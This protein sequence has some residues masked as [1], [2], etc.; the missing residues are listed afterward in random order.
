MKKI[1]W[2]ITELIV[3]CNLGWHM[4]VATLYENRWHYSIAVG[5]LPSEETSSVIEKGICNTQEEVI[6][7]MTDVIHKDVMDK[8]L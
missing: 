7:E 3:S 1:D 4:G 6:A 5:A 2:F 8:Y